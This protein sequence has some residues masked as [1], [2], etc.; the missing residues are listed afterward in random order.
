MAYALNATDAGYGMAAG[1]SS[2]L[3]L[4]QRGRLVLIGLPLMLVGALLV[5][6]LAMIA[7]PVSAASSSDVQFPDVESVT[8]LED[9]TLWGLAAEFAP[10][11]DPRVVVAEIVELNNLERNVLQVGQQVHVPVN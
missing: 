8:V 11:R 3:R 2:R 1:S 5:L 6:G 10:D 9:D 7:S 4:T